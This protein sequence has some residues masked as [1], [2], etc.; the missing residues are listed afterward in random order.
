MSEPYAEQRSALPLDHHVPHTQHSADALAEP[1]VGVQKRAVTRAPSAEGTITEVRLGLSPAGE[2]EL[3]E[4]LASD[5][6]PLPGAVERV[7]AS[8]RLELG[9]W[10]VQDRG[11]ETVD[12]FHLARAGGQLP[13][14]AWLNLQVALLEALD[15]QLRWVSAE[16]DALLD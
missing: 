6:S 12:R 15:P 4:I 8:H 9:R 3:V 14:S 7:L 11:A 2:L 5:R 16:L 13:R 10:E 1:A